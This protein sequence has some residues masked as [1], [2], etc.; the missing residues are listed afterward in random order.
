MFFFSF[1]HNSDHLSSKFQLL[2][3][4]IVLLIAPP[5]SPSPPSRSQL[6]NYKTRAKYSPR[7]PILHQNFTQRGRERR[8]KKNLHSVRKERKRIKRGKKE[9]G[10]IY[11]PK[12]SCIEFLG[13]IILKKGNT[14]LKKI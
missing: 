14:F 5:S 8:K 13:K 4:A 11:T 1:F 3:A 2:L 6:S 9:E 10:K 7:P 12:K